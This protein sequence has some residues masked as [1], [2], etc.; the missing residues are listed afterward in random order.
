MRAPFL[1]AF[2]AYA[3]ARIVHAREKQKAAFRLMHKAKLEDYGWRAAVA[4]L[5][6]A[7]V[8]LQYTDSQLDSLELASCTAMGPDP[9]WLLAYAKVR[10]E[11]LRAREELPLLQLQAERSIRWYEKA[12]A[13][14]TAGCKEWEAKVSALVAVDPEKRTAAW[15]T[16]LDRTS[17]ELGILQKEE[18]RHV[19]LLR[20]AKHEWTH[21]HEVPKRGGVRSWTCP[22]LLPPPAGPA[23]E[24]AAPDLDTDDEDGISA[25]P[26]FDEMG[27]GGEEV[28]DEMP[29][30][31][32]DGVCPGGGACKHAHAHAE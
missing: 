13:V 31:E 14:V 23:A 3:H 32:G 21:S 1:S 4:H 24:Y 27:P 20:L 30:A 28:D 7:S 5:M 26:V 29:E 22:A 16:Q 25:P 11:A 9:N 10:A 17:G 19:E 6:G 18:T 12:L 8:P 15:A 2:V